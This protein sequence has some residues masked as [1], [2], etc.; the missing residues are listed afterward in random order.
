MPSGRRDLPHIAGS[1]VAGGAFSAAVMS[2][3]QARCSR[4]QVPYPGGCW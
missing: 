2:W 1:R 3:V 4:S